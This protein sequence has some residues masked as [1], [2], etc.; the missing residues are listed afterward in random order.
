MIR[1][2]LTKTVE[3]PCPKRSVP[4]DACAFRA[5]FR[6]MLHCQPTK[7]SIELTADDFRN[8]ELSDEEMTAAQSLLGIKGF[9]APRHPESPRSSWL[10]LSQI[11]KYGLAMIA[12][13]MEADEK[14]RS[15]VMNG[16]VH[17]GFESH[18]F[19]YI[20]IE[21]SWSP[22]DATIFTPELER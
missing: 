15:L 6:N 1:V 10:V 8:W 7:I 12:A 13:G 16:R 3:L 17:C 20:R 11:E 21:A 18:P 9:P 2:D 14:F 22:A 5:L 19:G 4:A